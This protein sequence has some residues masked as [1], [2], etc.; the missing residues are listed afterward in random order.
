MQIRYINIC[1]CCLTSISSAA[2]RR[3][4][5]L[6]VLGVDLLL[7][8]RRIAALSTCNKNVTAISKCV[9]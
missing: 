6:A 3:F 5:L 4:V 7:F 1:T 9:P 8:W 2:F